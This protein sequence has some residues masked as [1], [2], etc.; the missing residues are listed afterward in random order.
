M[1]RDVSVGHSI[2]VETV[3]Q[4]IIHRIYII[5]GVLE[6]GLL[7]PAPNP[8]ATVHEMRSLPENTNF[9]PLDARKADT[10]SPTFVFSAR[11][12]TMRRKRAA[13]QAFLDGF[14]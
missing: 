4:G 1:P 10:C 2:Q 12:F 5:T 14:L 8:Q 13:T 9:L 7:V 11:T 3:L 6:L